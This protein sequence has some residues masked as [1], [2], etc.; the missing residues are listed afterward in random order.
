MLF[1]L[2]QHLFALFLKKLFRFIFPVYLTPKAAAKVIAFSFTS[3][4]NFQLF[5]KLY[6]SAFFRNSHY[7][8]SGCKD[9][10]LF[11]FCKLFVYLFLSLFEI[12]H[13]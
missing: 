1:S 8:L 9:S 4:F 5:K 13:I 12:I 7:L 10:Y 2:F 11:Y 3:T 6:R